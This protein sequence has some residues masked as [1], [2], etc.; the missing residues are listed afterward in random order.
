ML[1]SAQQAGGSLGPSILTTPSGSAAE[2]GTKK[3]SP[4]LLAHGI[5]TPSEPSLSTCPSALRRRPRRTADMGG[6]RDGHGEFPAGTECFQVPYARQSPVGTQSGSAS[7]RSAHLAGGVPAL[8][9]A[10]TPPTIAQVVSTSPPTP[11][12]VQK[13]AS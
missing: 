7:E 10:S 6:T 2:D 11:A 4:K 13:A 1:N 5:S 8:P 12:V 3:Q 9:E